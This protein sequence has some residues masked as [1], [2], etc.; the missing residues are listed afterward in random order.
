MDPKH[1]QHSIISSSTNKNTNYTTQTSISIYNTINQKTKRTHFLLDS[2][3]KT[4]PKAQFTNLKAT[5]HIR[6][7]KSLIIY[8]TLRPRRKKIRET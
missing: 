7:K 4:N 3:L 1:I 5:L 2:T 6:N 8:T